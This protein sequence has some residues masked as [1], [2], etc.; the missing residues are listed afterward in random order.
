MN[1]R[2]GASIRIDFSESARNFVSISLQ[3]GSVEENLCACERQRK[4][5]KEKEESFKASKD[6]AR[7]GR[8]CS[9]RLCPGINQDSNVNNTGC[10]Y[11]IIQVQSLSHTMQLQPSLHYTEIEGVEE[12]GERGEGEGEGEG[13]EGG[14]GGGGGG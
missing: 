3:E 6:I 14:G 10:L 7:L 8:K 11:V 1:H 13:G 2:N 12:E 5:D 9:K 4:I